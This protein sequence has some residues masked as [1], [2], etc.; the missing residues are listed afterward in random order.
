MLGGRQGAGAAAAAGG[1]A[2]GAPP[3][4]LPWLA[5]R[6]RVI[7][8]AV[9]GCAQCRLLV[10]IDVVLHVPHGRHMPAT[11]LVSCVR[12]QCRDPGSA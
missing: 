11:L 10:F 8:E 3:A 6:I 12:M 7:K 9:R 4:L 5:E 1:S 2:G